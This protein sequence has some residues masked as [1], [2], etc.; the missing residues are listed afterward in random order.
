MQPEDY[1]E[2]Q[3]EDEP[4]SYPIDEFQLT[5]TPNDFNIITIISFIKS[6]VFKIPNFQR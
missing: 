1:E 2:K 5:T 4:E 3:Y 6:K